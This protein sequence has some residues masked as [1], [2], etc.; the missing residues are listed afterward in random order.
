[1][2]HDVIVEPWL[3]RYQRVLEN[4]VQAPDLHRPRRDPCPPE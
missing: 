1:M 2:D 4:I 3:D